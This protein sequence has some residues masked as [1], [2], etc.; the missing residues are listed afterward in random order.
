MRKIRENLRAYGG[1]ASMCTLT[2]PGEAAGLVW[3]RARCS[4]QPGERCDGRKPYITTFDLTSED[5]MAAVQDEP[6][7]REGGDAFEAWLARAGRD[8]A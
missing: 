4:H 2:A 8:S 3:D 5:A 7:V 1:L 6:L